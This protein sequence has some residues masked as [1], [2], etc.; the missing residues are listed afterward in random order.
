VGRGSRE[1]VVMMVKGRRLCGGIFGWV[2][3]EYN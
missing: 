2:G 3:R 1:G